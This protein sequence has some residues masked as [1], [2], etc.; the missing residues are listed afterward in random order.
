MVVEVKS[1]FVK[2][3]KKLPPKIQLSVYEVLKK[4]RIAESLEKSGTDYKKMEGLKKGES[5][6]RVRVGQWRI[7]IEYLHPAV[8]IITV[9]SRGDIYKSFPPGKK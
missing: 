1:S 8:I 6:Y 9:L 2:E 7:G 4:L 5:F 3:L